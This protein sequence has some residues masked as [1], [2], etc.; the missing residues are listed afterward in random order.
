MERYAPFVLHWKFFS[1][2]NQLLTKIR[3]ASCRTDVLYCYSRHL[4]KSKMNFDRILK[5]ELLS[6]MK[7]FSNLLPRFDFLR[8]YE[9][10]LKASEG[11]FM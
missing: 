7:N 4:M 10:S 8:K 2:A 6:F 1:N 5:H 11:D 3:L 9:R